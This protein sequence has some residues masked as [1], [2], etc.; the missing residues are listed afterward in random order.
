MTLFFAAT[1]V[2]FGFAGRRGATVLAAG[3]LRT[4]FLLGA[5]FATFLPPLL[6]LEVFLATLF[7]AG[8]AFFATGRDGFTAGF[9]A[10]AAA[11]GGRTGFFFSGAAGLTTRAAFA[12]V[13][14]AVESG[15]RRDVLVAG[16]AVTA[17]RFDVRAESPARFFG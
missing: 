1:A 17:R 7:F 9:F 3:F 2:R 6:L 12:L 16:G 11:A 13:T 5:F 10:F 4:G 14:D 8:G 15:V